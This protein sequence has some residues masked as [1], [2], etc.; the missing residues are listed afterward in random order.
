[1]PHLC[2]T[3]PL[4]A[5]EIII[6]H[7]HR[8]GRLPLFH[9]ALPRK[10]ECAGWL[11]PESFI[12]SHRQRHGVKP[13]IGHVIPVGHTHLWRRN[14][15]QTVVVVPFSRLL[16]HIYLEASQDTHQVEPLLFHLQ[17]GVRDISSRGSSKSPKCR[18][19]LKTKVLLVAVPHLPPTHICLLLFKIEGIREPLPDNATLTCIKALPG[20]ARSYP[21]DGV[22]VDL[23]LCNL[24]VAHPHS[25]CLAD[26][27]GS[28][29]SENGGSCAS[30]IGRR[31]RHRPNRLVSRFI[32][33]RNNRIA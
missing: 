32:I 28:L 11:R 27:G 19:G 13:L 1:M 7:H 12:L 16:R 2:V 24:H 29:F 21:R 14:E 8:F 15:R 4:S 9:V 22:P 5:P 3:Q 26:A 6:A 18:H 20:S 33:P 10:A 23:F 17:I 25:D 31:H 30:I